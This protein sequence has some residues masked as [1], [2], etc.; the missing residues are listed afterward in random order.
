MHFC[1]LNSLTVRKT[2]GFLADFFVFSVSKTLETMNRGLDF[3]V[4][5]NGIVSTLDRNM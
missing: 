5:L 3:L 4:G 1:H 2:K